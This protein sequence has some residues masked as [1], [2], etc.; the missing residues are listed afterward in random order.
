MYAHHGH[1]TSSKFVI[2]I[3][4]ISRPPFQALAIWMF[5]LIRDLKPK[6]KNQQFVFVAHTHKLA[7]CTF[8]ETCEYILSMSG[9][10]YRH[11]EN[12]NIAFK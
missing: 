8:Y 10:N 6:T 7:L 12:A 2:S 11:I 1:V 3:K 9:M 4:T 5:N